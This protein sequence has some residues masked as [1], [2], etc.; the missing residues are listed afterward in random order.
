MVTNLESPGEELILDLQEVALGLLALE[1]FV[2]DREADIVLDILPS[3]VA[4]L[5][6]ACQQPVV[7]TT[8]PDLMFASSE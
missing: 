7:M 8:V 4:V 6:D 3:A 5:D 1:G 2:D